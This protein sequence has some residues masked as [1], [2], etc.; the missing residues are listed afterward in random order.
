MNGLGWSWGPQDRPQSGN[1]QRPAAAVGLEAAPVSGAAASPLQPC[2]WSSPFIYPEE[3]SSQPQ[4]SCFQIKC[5]L[6]LLSY[7]AAFFLNLPDFLPSPDE[8]CVTLITMS[9]FKLVTIPREAK[10]SGEGIFG[11]V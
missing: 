3:N 2:P 7:R 11:C 6:S 1:K 8:R 4:S 9:M 5:H 10:G